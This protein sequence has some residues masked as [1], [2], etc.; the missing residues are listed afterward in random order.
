MLDK[1]YMKPFAM[2]S[3]IG[4]DNSQLKLK[5]IGTIGTIKNPRH[6]IFIAKRYMLKLCKEKY[7]A[8]VETKEPI[9]IIFRIVVYRAVLSTIIEKVKLPTM[10]DIIETTLIIEV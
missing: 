5:P 9:T 2:A 4:Y 1:N 6:I 10:P 8:T 7:R 3:L